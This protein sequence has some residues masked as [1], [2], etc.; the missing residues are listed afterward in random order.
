MAAARP[1]QHLHSRIVPKSFVVER[2]Q[3][4]VR[5]RCDHLPELK[6]LR[7]G[8]RRCPGDVKA[9]AL[10]LAGELPTVLHAIKGPRS[11]GNER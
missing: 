11:C 4:R 6:G 3:S 10:A 2:R 8:H 7:H 1:G 9:L 5:L